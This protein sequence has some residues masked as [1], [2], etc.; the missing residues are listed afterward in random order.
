MPSG[1]ST[2][3]VYLALRTLYLAEP[4]TWYHIEVVAMCAGLSV[5]T[6]RHVVKDYH[7]WMLEGRHG[8]RY[9]YRLSEFAGAALLR[10]AIR[11][12]AAFTSKVRVSVQMLRCANDELT[13]LIA[14]ERAKLN[15]EREACRAKGWS[16][17]WAPSTTPRLDELKK[18][19]QYLPEPHAI[20][21][22][23]E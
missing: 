16:T 19:R 15:E 7:N 3:K 9:N 21:G 17:S 12:P 14:V 10:D 23:K 6:V 2:E 13:H 20:P 1:D 5:T 22:P 18:I 8:R 11:E 4:G